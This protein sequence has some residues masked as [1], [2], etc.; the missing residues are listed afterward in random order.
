M[1]SPVNY[2]SL[3]DTN[4]II[5]ERSNEDGGLSSR[6]LSPDKVNQSDKRLSQNCSPLSTSSAYELEAPGTQN[7]HNTHNSYSYNN[8][9]RFD[10]SHSTSGIQ[11][12]TCLQRK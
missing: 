10:S 6:Q 5:E 3:L 1:E 2:L 8:K 9:G 12:E 4:Q 11:K 7:T